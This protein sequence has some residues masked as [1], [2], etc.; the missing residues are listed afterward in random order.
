MTFVDRTKLRE[1]GLTLLHIASQLESSKA[2]KLLCEHVL[3]MGNGDPEMSYNDKKKYLRSWINER[4]DCDNKFTALH[5]ASY[6]GNHFLA[7]YLIKKGA[8]FQLLA[9][10]KLN[11]LHV[12]A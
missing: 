6:M 10:S 11:M 9:E 5:Y 1:N 3:C 2:A 8:D 4:T 12:A 7:Q